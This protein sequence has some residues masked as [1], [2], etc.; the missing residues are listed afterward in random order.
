M[1]VTFLA[2]S[3]PRF[4]G[5]Y[6]GVFIYD[7]ARYL[8]QEGVKIQVI[9]PHAEGTIYKEK[10]E[11]VQVWRF[12]Y[13]YPPQQQHIAY[14]AGIP[15]NL[16]RSWRARMQL[17]FFLFSFFLSMGKFCRD[18]DII[19]AHWIEPAFLSLP[20][21]KWYD[22][23]LVVSLHRYNPSGSVGTFVYKAVFTQADHILF[24]STFT[25]QCGQRDF[26][27][28]RQSVVPPGLD[29]SKF[30]CKGQVNQKRRSPFTVFSLGSLL[31]VKGFIHLVESI[32]YIINMV[33]CQFVI[34]GQGPERDILW[35]RAKVLNVTDRLTLLGRVA[36]DEVP[37]LMREADVFVLPSIRHE[38]GDTESL[39]MVLAEALASGT[40][41]VA[42]RTGGIV[43]I[44]ED[45]V[46]GYLVTPG[47]SQE[48]AEKLALILQDD[49][50]RLQ[51][52]QLGRE[53][54]EK[55]FSLP[56]VAEKVVAV[57]RSLLNF[58]SNAE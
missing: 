19:H 29:T 28:K 35:Q 5:D 34:G 27:T 49:S 7:L 51:M 33:D 44:V 46:T 32:P 22:K 45:G 30:F 50:K 42:S 40:P 54:I 57:Y 53:K 31:P 17:P 3:F 56:A 36:T 15:T 52:G 26:P 1:K 37:G 25:Q 39:G 8:A 2:T 10:I 21:R 58:G 6:A 9:A 24:N 4:K 13:F 18:A 47:D 55:Q 41:C 20:W 11:G 12:P 48:L 38:S 16:R 23:P 14:G 43:D